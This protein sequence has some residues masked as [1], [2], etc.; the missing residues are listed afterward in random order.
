MSIFGYLVYL[1]FYGERKKIVEKDLDAKVTDFMIFLSTIVIM[2]EL[3]HIKFLA[4]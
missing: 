4:P 2:I 1:V 3:L